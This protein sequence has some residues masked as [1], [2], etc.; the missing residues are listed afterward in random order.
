MTPWTIACRAPLSMG[1]PRKEYWSG[2]PCPPLGDLPMPGIE[3]MHPVAPELQVDS[4]LLSHW[5]SPYYKY[6]VVKV[7]HVVSPKK[8]FLISH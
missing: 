8:L 3:L 2:L 6:P 7:H 4:L 1:F 5:G